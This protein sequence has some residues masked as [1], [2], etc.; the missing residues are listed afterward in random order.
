MIRHKPILAAILTFCL[1]ILA[2]GP[3][4]S[5]G[6]L[7]QREA[8]YPQSI[9]VREALLIRERNG[10]PMIIAS[11]FLISRARGLFAS[12]KH[13]IGSESDGQ[14]KIFF[15]GRVYDGALLRLPPVTD[16]AIIRI[17][18]GYDMTSFPEPYPIANEVKVND[19]V[20]I[21]GFHPHD[22]ELQTGKTII[23][24]LRLYYGLLGKREEF[25][26]DDLE[27]RIVNVANTVQNKKIGGSSE[28]LSEVSNTYFKLNTRR[29]H[30]MSFAGLSGGP[31]VNERGELVGINSFQEEARIEEN[32]RGMLE[33][34]PWI[35]LN[36]VPAGELATLM[37]Q[38]GIN[39]Q[40]P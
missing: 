38:L 32:A 12:A 2:C 4:V 36:L 3:P 10:E 5:V 31:T 35:N 19:E 40:T 15:N 1:F 14:C 16:I 7:Y 29:D 18:G 22:K 25:V 23:P 28:I 11:A 37:S 8:R 6:N 13:F 33:Y 34:I 17:E 30:Q 21:R 39:H 9:K 26:Y 27:G 24:I 20:F